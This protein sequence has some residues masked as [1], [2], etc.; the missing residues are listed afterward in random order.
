MTHRSWSGAV[1]TQDHGIGSTPTVPC[2]GPYPMASDSKNPLVLEVWRGKQ[3]LQRAEF[4][5]P[6]VTLG[7][8]QSAMLRVD[9]PAISE[10]H[11]V[12]NVEDDGTLLVLDLGGLGGIQVNGEQVAN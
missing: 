6:S 11:A 10:L 4:F 7:S 8:G 2:G 3:L 9:S 1:S 5:E 12:V